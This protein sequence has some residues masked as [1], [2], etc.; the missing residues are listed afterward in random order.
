MCLGG[1]KSDDDRRNAKTKTETSGVLG[2]SHQNV[3]KKPVSN[4]LYLYISGTQSVGLD[5]F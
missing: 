3:G 2:C 1:C 4:G 5:D